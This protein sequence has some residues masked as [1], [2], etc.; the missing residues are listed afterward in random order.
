MSSQATLTYENIYL[1]DLLLLWL[2]WQAFVHTLLKKWECGT[3][4]LLTCITFSSHKPLLLHIFQ[5]S[6]QASVLLF[7]MAGFL[8][9]VQSGQNLASIDAILLTPTIPMVKF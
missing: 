8:C 9:K 7:N 4:W 5:A 3:S 2:R 1:Y 6:T